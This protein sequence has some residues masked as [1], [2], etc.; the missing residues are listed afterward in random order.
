MPTVVGMTTSAFDPASRV[1]FIQFIPH[2]R[3]AGWTVRHLPNRPDRQWRSAL[4]GRVP[5]GLHYRAGRALM[6]VNP[7][8]DIRSCASADVVFV[9]RD[10]A[11]RGSFFQK[12]LI[13]VN[14]R[15]VFDF[16]D[17]IYLGNAAPVE[18]MCRHAALVTT[19]NEYLASFARQYT[20]RVTVLPTVID[21]DQYVVAGARLSGP[22]RV[23]WSGSDLSIGYGLFPYL[24]MLAEAQRRAPFELVV[25]TNTRPNISTPGLR[26][27]FRPWRAED[28][29]ALGRAMDIGL[30]PL[31]D[32]EF[33]R[34]KCGL[35]L[36]QYMA[37]GI[38]TVASPVGVNRDITI[39]GTTGL[40]ATTPAEWV[41]AL[42]T[43]V[44]SSAVRRTMGAAGRVRCER[45]YSVRRWMPDLLQMLTAVANPGA[46]P[47][48]GRETAARGAAVS[49]ETHRA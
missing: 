49:F 6:K 29:G 37:A 3:R 33:E 28:E 45:E 42:T 16:D 1:R 23:G 10:L 7:W 27:S 48:I 2:L 8:R 38:P 22:V 9:N 15:V 17:A 26:W 4:P 24:E 41:E 14:P 12:Q 36:L 39:D 31:A 40:L 19:G 20:D 34:A 47:A 21:T 35:K 46:E 43:L 44:S 18:W 30:M 11:G 32:N 25:V 5:R 13:R